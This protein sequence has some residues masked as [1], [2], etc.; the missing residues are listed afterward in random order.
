M[1]SGEFLQCLRNVFSFSSRLSLPSVGDLTTAARRPCGEEDILDSKRPHFSSSRA[2][3]FLFLLGKREKNSTSRAFDGQRD[4][5]TRSCPVAGAEPL[6]I[7]FFLLLSGSSGMFI[8]PFAPHQ[9]NSTRK[10]S[11]LCRLLTASGC[12]LSVASGEE[13]A[14]AAAVTGRGARAGGR[15]GCEE[16]ASLNNVGAVCGRFLGGLSPRC[17]GPVGLA[18]AR[19]PPGE[20]GRA[21][22]MEI[23]ALGRGKG[24]A[25]GGRARGVSRERMESEVKQ[26]SQGSGSRKSCFSHHLAKTDLCHGAASPCAL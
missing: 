17:E 8:I 14:E 3:F 15:G 10:L 18:S 19:A 25:A 21:R 12:A 2:S 6:L 1:K 20:E 24:R 4:E 26:S 9:H 7:V 22:S 5:R 13:G 11:H 23:E 16:E